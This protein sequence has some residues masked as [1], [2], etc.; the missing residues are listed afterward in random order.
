MNGSVVLAISGF[1]SD[2][3]VIGLLEQVFSDMH[4]EIASVIIVDSLGSGKLPKEIASRGWFVRYENA[5]R[6]LGSAGNL[7]RRLARAASTGAEWCL[8]MNHDANWSSE[9]LNSMLEVAKSRD[10]VGAI[11]PILHHG[12]RENPWEDGRRSF[13]P[14]AAKRYPEIPTGDSKPEVLWSSSNGA[15]YA[16]APL[17]ESITVME[18]LWMGYEDLAYGIALFRGGWLQLVCREAVLKDIFDLA[19]SRFCRRE[20]YIAD[21]PIWYSYYNIRNLLL[22]RKR[23]GADGVSYPMIAH[24]LLQS[25]L[26]ILAL[27]DKK[28]AR[29]LELYR[30]TVA[31]LLGR[32]GKGSRP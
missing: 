12:K 23:Y 21:K 2:D 28:G 8:C 16:T 25:T 3:A 32:S 13:A 18:D 30:G 14:S 24:K 4:P 1:R 5:D 26:R 17:S 31:G 19:P 20:M 27:E 6:N 29:L 9:R 11:Y 10:R 15:L 22:I 7:A